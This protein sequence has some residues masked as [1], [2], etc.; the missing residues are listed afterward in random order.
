MS[1]QA[2]RPRSI[3]LVRCITEAV[4]Y[5][6]RLM[7][8]RSNRAAKLLTNNRPIA[9]NEHLYNQAILIGYFSFIHVFDLKDGIFST[10]LKRLKGKIPSCK[11]NLPP[12]LARTCKAIFLRSLDILHEAQWA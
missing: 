3:Y 10:V 1:S 9:S 8:A 4:H 6:S 11:G 5:G 2:E 12:Y 7:R